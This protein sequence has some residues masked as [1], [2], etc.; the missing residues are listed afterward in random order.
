MSSPE[1]ELTV[2][3][4][5]IQGQSNI[6]ETKQKQI[7]DFLKYFNID[8]LHLQEIEISQNTFKHCYYISSNYNIIQN[9]NPE[10]KYGTASLIRQDLFV[11]NVKCDTEG[12]AIVFDINNMTFTNFY[13]HSGNDRVMRQNRENCLSHTIPQ[14]L[15]N[16][17]DSGLISADFNCIVD[18]KD[19]IKN[20]SQKMS[21]S[22]KRLIKVF[23][24][25]DSFRSVSPE[26]QIFSRYYNSKEYGPGA[27]RIDRIYHFGDVKVKEANYIG[28]SFS[29]HHSLVVKIKIDESFSKL[30][31]PKSCLLFKAS[32]LVVKDS[33]FKKRLKEHFVIW[34]EKKQVVEFMVWLE[35]PY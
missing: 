4:L 18:V 8:I 5:N 13:L 31:S 28:V 29:D 14:L 1:S 12:R 6:N 16:K 27:T 17:K 20:P 30:L 11:Q 34:E 33:E 2:A 25:V 22:L 32:P 10:N 15:V 7:E 21:S 9:N 26:A 24:L 35:S 23:P 19:T 3:T